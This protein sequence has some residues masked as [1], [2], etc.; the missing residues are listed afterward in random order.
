MHIES[1][2]LLARMERDYPG[3]FEHCRLTYLVELQ[4]AE[5]DRLTAENERLQ[6]DVDRYRPGVPAP[7][8]QTRTFTSSS[9]PH[10]EQDSTRG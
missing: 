3:E 2:D 4:A 1:D 5:I 10:L 9:F 7:L 6:A 8:E